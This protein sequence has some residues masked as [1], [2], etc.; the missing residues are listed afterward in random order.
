MPID[1]SWL[2]NF[3]GLKEKNGFGSSNLNSKTVLA[4]PT[5]FEETEHDM[6]ERVGKFCQDQSH[7]LDNRVSRME[8]GCWR[9]ECSTREGDGERQT[10]L[11]PIS[12]IGFKPGQL[13]VVLGPSQNAYGPLSMFQ[14]PDPMVT[15]YKDKSVDIV[16]GRNHSEGCD[17][18]CTSG[19]TPALLN[20]RAALRIYF[21][22][23][24]SGAHNPPIL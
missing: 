4:K 5:G 8:D 11:G 9:G 12:P 3:L 16:N 13:S 17:S 14:E 2:K 6:A 21:R 7:I 22:W 10:G 1:H 20:G 15:I 19:I 23:G 24:S 18:E